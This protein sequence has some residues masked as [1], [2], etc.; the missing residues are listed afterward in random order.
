M[1]DGKRLSRIHNRPDGE[2]TSGGNDDVNIE[3]D[4]FGRKPRKPIT[5]SLGISVLSGDV[6]SF[7]VAK[8]AQRL[9][10]SLGTGG[11]SSC[12]GI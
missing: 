11:V 12:I 9:P 10:N 7:Y 6:L 4:Q 2:R 1:S 8:L 5:L 3:T